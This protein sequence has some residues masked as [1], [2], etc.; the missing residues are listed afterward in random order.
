MEQK[1][2]VGCRICYEHQARCEMLSSQQA[3]VHVQIENAE[4]TQN[5]SALRNLKLDAFQVTARLRETQDAFLRHQ[6]DA[7]TTF[8]AA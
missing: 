3:A 8:R 1:A 7:H 6:R 2:V 5:K 4:Q